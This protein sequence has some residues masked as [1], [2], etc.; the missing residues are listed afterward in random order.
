MSGHPEL[1]IPYTLTSAFCT[2][3]TGFLLYLP[4]LDS[5]MISCGIVRIIQ[6]GHGEGMAD[7]EL[8]AVVVSITRE[9]R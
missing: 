9:S 4:K 6:A 2:R 7:Q 8:V 5:D 3:I 1:S